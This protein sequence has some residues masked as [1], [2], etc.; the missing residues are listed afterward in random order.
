MGKVLVQCGALEEARGGPLAVPRS[1][2]PPLED[3]EPAAATDGAEGEALAQGAAHAVG[4]QGADSEAAAQAAPKSH[5]APAEVRVRG[6]GCCSA[7]Q[8]ARCPCKHAT[9]TWPMDLAK[10]L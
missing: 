6:S 1:S 4:A 5:A 2:A 3:A 10:C 7:A 9:R 8:R